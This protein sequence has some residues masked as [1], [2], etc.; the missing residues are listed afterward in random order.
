MVNMKKLFTSGPMS[1]RQI[2]RLTRF[3]AGS[4]LETVAEV[5]FPGVGVVREFA[6][7]SGS[8]DLTV[9]H[10]VRALGNLQGRLHIM[11]RDQD[12]DVAL[13]KL[14]DDLLDILNRDRVDAGER[15]VQENESG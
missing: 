7:R 5:V 1:S 2:I 8:L 9:C 6:R 11:I 13:F 15:F 12:A 4:M 14:F 10:N 3:I